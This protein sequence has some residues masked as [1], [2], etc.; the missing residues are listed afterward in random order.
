VH[1]AFIPDIRRG[2]GVFRALALGATAVGV[3][4]PMLFGAALGGP[5]GVQSV[6]DHLTTELHKT[7]L[8][9]GAQSTKDIDRN[10]LLPRA[11]HRKET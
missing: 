9:A 10:D 3:G 5:A 11:L 6:L 4:R 7:M 1:G 2:I 8:L